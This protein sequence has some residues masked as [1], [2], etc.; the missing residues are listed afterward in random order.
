MKTML[1]IGY[2][3]SKVRHFP[4]PTPT[5]HTSVARQDLEEL[6]RDSPLPWIALTSISKLAQRQNNDVTRSFGRLC[7]KITSLG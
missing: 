6:P 4:L 1:A 7:H 5:E 2:T 3:R